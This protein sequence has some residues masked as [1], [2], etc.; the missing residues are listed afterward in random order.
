MTL[1]LCLFGLI[2]CNYVDGKPFDQFSHESRIEDYKD[3]IKNNTE[4]KRNEE[5]SIEI[6]E[7]GKNITLAFV[8]NTTS[9]ED[10]IDYIEPKKVLTGLILY[11]DDDLNIASISDYNVKITESKDCAAEEDKVW[12]ETGIKMNDQA[13]VNGKH[14]DKFPNAVTEAN[15]D[16]TNANDDKYID[17]LNENC[18]AE[19]IMENIDPNGNESTKLTIA[20]DYEIMLSSIVESHVMGELE[21]KEKVE[22]NSRA[23]G[24]DILRMYIFNNVI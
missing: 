10:S 20:D 23:V 22:R 21:V 3:I 7:Y 1:S 18:S 19:G 17:V 11:L 16:Q 8:T 14:D 13:I 2:L 6:N 9:L 15:K 24:S 4:T 5:V 12:N